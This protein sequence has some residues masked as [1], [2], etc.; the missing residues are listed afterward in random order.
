MKSLDAGEGDLSK[1]RD[2]VR[3]GILRLVKIQDYSG[4][5]PFWPGGRQPHEWASAYATFA[6]LEA[7][8]AGFYVPPVVI[9]RA[10][11]FLRDGE[12]TRWSAF[13]LAKSGKY[14]LR[15]R[16]PEK[17]KKPGKEDLLLTAGTLY[18]AGYPQRAERVLEKAK[19]ARTAKK[20]KG[21]TFFS[22]LRLKALKLY[23]TFLI[24]P[25]SKENARLAQDLMGRLNEHPTWYYTTQEL[26]WSLVALG[27]YLQS[28]SLRPVNA[29]LIRGET[30][31]PVVSALSGVL[32]WNLKEKAARSLKLKIK[33]PAVAWVSMTIQGYRTEGFKPVMDK[34]LT[35]SRRLLNRDGKAVTDI[36]AGDLLYMDITLNNTR[37]EVLRR[38][39]V[40]IPMVAG[41]EVVNKRL[42]GGGFP[43]WA[44]RKGIFKPSYVDIRDEEVR[45]FGNLSKGKYHYYLLVRA[46]FRYQGKMPP[47]R[48]ELMYR[49]WIYSIGEPM[50]LQV[51]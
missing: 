29:T 17:G 8:E 12:Y 3:S 40:R 23:M 49:P 31:L 38:V 27:R 48:A 15:H 39:A 45:F 46:T 33:S 13:V 47:V 11:L 22:P 32:T 1:I 16:R 18:Y 14:R 7:K 2:R 21:E 6:L 4:G 19:K 26:A 9:Q 20:R 50:E 24:T 35:I 28:L 25:K 5:F 36:K 42:F 44:K 51:K 34:G 30:P 43:G 10:L 37:K 41:L